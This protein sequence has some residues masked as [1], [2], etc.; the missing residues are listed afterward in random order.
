MTVEH[1]RSGMMVAL[2]AW[3]GTYEIRDFA[4]RLEHFRADR[5]AGAAGPSDLVVSKVDKQTWR[6]AAPA[7]VSGLENLSVVHIAYDVYWDEA[8]PF[9]SQL[10]AHHAFLNLADILLYLPDR[11]GEEVVLVFDD[12]PSSWKAA[13]E[14]PTA[15]A[16]NAF[17][18]AS[19]DALV[20]APAELSAFDEFSFDAKG[21]HFRVVV[22][23]SGWKENEL[24]ESLSR[25]AT[26]ET[27]LMG[28]P[29]FREYM[30]LFHFGPYSEI[31]GGG[32]EHANATAISAS[33][34]A[35]AAA[36]AAHEFFHAWNVKRIRPQ[37][38][39]PLDYSREMWTRALWFAEGV[40]ST[41]G[42][43][44]LLRARIWKREQFLGDLAAQLAQLDSRPARGWQSVE[45]S[46]LDTWLERYDYYR[47]PEVSISYYNKG[48]I[49]GVLLDLAI[50]D[51]T[52][53]HKSLDDVLRTL[54][55]EFARRGRF[56][57][58]SADIEA[59]VE[60]VAGRSF[61]EFFTDY[62]AGTQEIPYD[63]FLALAGWGLKGKSRSVAALD[64]ETERDPDGSVV[65]SQVN[66]G[67]KAEAGGLRAGDLVLELN[68]A[69]FP[70]SPS[71]WE[72][73]QKP[74]ETVRLR[75]QRNGEE[76][77]IAFALGERE[78]QSY[79]IT[80]VPQTSEKQQRIREGILQGVT[81]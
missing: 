57:N 29:P 9:S 13:I 64:F 42:A 67:S 5:R 50:R 79:E 75:L 39:E 22:D 55:E 73:R 23:G 65:V 7:D 58:D 49:L 71:R 68:G 14:L 33:S 12:L 59:A 18:A 24:R 6:I 52:N 78:E 1:V 40:T 53:N 36:I 19:Y 38:L 45:E 51:A 10:N 15:G 28:G 27:T 63:Q 80:E 66:H 72:S 31:G 3:N 76:R 16:P 11:R 60:K 2:P 77:T 69:A 54:N 17:L 41:Y 43:Y 61:E 46:S 74:G 47:R 34:D 37:S 44:S 81:Q 20:D 48:Q 8:G 56:Y 21:A 4:Y 70:R 32:M 35:G 26:Y 30:F 62:V 25:I